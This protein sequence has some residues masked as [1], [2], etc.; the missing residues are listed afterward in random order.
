MNIN[1]LNFEIITSMYYSCDHIGGTIFRRV[2]STLNYYQT[3]NFLDIIF[4]SKL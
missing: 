2:K 3:M 4:L 1:K